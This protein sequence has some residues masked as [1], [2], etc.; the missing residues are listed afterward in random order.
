ML[1]KKCKEVGIST[2]ACFL[3]GHPNED[4]NDHELTSAYLRS[5]CVAGLS[6]AAI[7]IVSPFAGSELHS[8][9][10]I[11]FVDEDKLISF[12]P[13]ARVGYKLL[14]KRRKE[15]IRIF[16]FQ[17]I[18]QFVPLLRHAWNATFGKPQT[19][20]ENLPSRAFYMFKI[21]LMHRIRGKPL[22]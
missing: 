2:Q 4:P 11:H 22:L 16:V 9:G 3:V 5:L 14:A 21:L 20:I 8:K 12:S 18:R 6:E 7:F 19:K 13:T 17:K 1:V 15:L 10:A